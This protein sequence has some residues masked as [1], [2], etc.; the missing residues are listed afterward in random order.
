MSDG[1]KEEIKWRN[2]FCKR[3]SIC[4]F[5]CSIVTV[6][7]SQCRKE[8]IVTKS[9]DMWNHFSPMFTVSAHCVAESPLRNKGILITSLLS[10]RALFVAPGVLCLSRGDEEQIK[11]VSKEKYEA[12][13]LF[14]LSQVL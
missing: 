12:E 2:Y 10:P 4:G 13:F 7:I 14:L 8:L 6:L 11:Y 9:P 3:K 1:F 5:F